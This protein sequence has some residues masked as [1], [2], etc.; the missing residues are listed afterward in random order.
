M[1]DASHRLLW[2]AITVKPRHEKAVSQALESKGLEA[3]LPLYRARRR[4]SDRVKELD[5]PLFTGYV[6]CRFPRPERARVLATPGVN[7][8]V[9]F[10]NQ[11][12][13]IPEVEVESIR[14]LV[15]NG[16]A[17]RPCPHL[18][19]GERV[20]IE[21]G[22][23]AGVEGVLTQLKDAW[24]VVVSVD[25]LRRSVAAEVERDAVSAVRPAARSQYAG[26]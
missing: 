26:I 18:E 4:W 19:V 21:A 20:R 3:F 15:A 23:L 13:E 2:F 7:S 24:R 1:T 12:A 22:P 16:T 25:L 6:F 9:S 11:P 14:T 8:V 10:G 17:I 5:L